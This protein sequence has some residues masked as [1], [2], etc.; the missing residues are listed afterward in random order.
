MKKTIGIIGFGN[1]GQALADRLRSKYEVYVSD[2]DKDRIKNIRGL[3]VSYNNPDLL[4]KVDTLILA[5]KP[6]DLDSVL[7]EI[8]NHS[9]DKLIISI[10]AGADTA[11][12]EKVLDG[13][14]VVR[15]MPNMPAKIGKGMSCLC[16]GSLAGEEDLRLAKEL[17]DNLGQTLIIEEDMMNAATAVSGSGPGFFCDLVQKDNTMPPE[18]FAKEVFQIQLTRAAVA[19]GFDESQASV[20]ASATT[21]GTLAL[22]KV[23]GLPPEKLCA[24]VTSKGGTTEAGLEILHKGGSLAEA[25]KAAVK[26]AEE[27]SRG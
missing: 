21:Q 27:L 1:M 16:K 10:A 6:Q 25:V 3:E 23:T 24:Q 19:V 12:I 18:K 11:H 4:S 5:V 26:R 13:R 8:K 14:R 7:N 17:F 15:V 20:L 22:I 2:K 9:K